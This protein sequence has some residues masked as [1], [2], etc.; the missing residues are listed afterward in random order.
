MKGLNIL[1]VLVFFWFSNQAQENKDKKELTILTTRAFGIYLN[2]PD[3]AIALAKRA[4]DI[5]LI[6][7]DR[8][9]TG[10]SYYILSKA[11]WA[12]TNYRLST[13]YGF[14]ALRI[15]ENTNNKTNWAL[16]QLSLARTLVELGNIAK[17]GELIQ[18][19]KQL[20][21]EAADEK[22]LAEVYRENSYLLSETNQLD[23]ALVYADK[24]IKMYEA[25]GDSLNASVLYGRKSRIYFAKRNFELSRKFAF[26]AILLDTLVGNR[27]GL[28]IA[29]FSAAQ[30][31][32]AMKD[33]S[34][35]AKLLQ[36]SIR[37]NREIGNLT[38]LV[39]AHELLAKLYMEI[40]KPDKA[41][42][43]LLLASQYKDNL[44]NSEKNGQ[45]QEMESLYELEAKNN[46]IKLLEQQ[47]IL[48]QQEGKNQRL[49]MAVLIAGVFL[50]V[51]VIFFLTRLRRI[52][53]KTNRDLAVKNKAIEQQ[54]EEMQLQAEKL[55]KL[56]HLQTKLFS[57]ISHDLRGPIANLQALLDMFTK[58][59]MTA[60]EFVGLSDKLK[61]NMNVTQ[62][63]LENLLNWALSQ[64]EGIK[65][66]RKNIDIKLCIEEATRLMEEVAH[67]KNIVLRKNLS[68]SLMVLA[69]PDQVQLILRNLIHNGI[70]FSK[71][72]DQVVISAAKENEFCRITIEDTG[73]G[74]SEEDIDTIIGSKEHFSKTGTMAEKGT[75]IGL[76]LC[77]E[78]IERNGGTLSFQSKLKE[79]TSVSFTLLL[80]Q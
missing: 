42:A 68:E 33:F 25:L 76:L 27:R 8:F 56:N 21:L 30:N 18:Q 73:I 57:V 43:H 67:R 72:G 4:L 32:Y 45:I 37:I 79:G 38:W 69:D 50:M 19:A 65:T 12:K 1:C 58:K 29:Y 60:E 39:R 77:K 22:I 2:N 17:A 11:F 26:R 20:G 28:G 74:M 61:A 5:A 62:R 15:F 49:F 51:V 55:Q 48:Q 71:I 64:M 23:S 53:A 66:E 52:Q 35:A 7:N 3:T 36:H 70:K 47:N 10:H 40:K 16:S 44:Y 24:G 80:A 13:E 6:A 63:T 46:R 75:G 34:S 78:F 59:L 31:A 54:R 14:K 41:A 9:Y